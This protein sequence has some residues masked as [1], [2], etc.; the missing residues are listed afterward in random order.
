MQTLSFSLIPLLLILGSLFSHVA[1]KAQP[2][3]SPARVIRELYKVHNDG[4]GGIFE[5]KGK[6]YIYKFF[7]QKLADLIWKDITETPEGE[8]G[9]L[10]F[11]PLYN[12]QDTGITN[13]QIGKPMVKGDESTVL[14]SFRNFG[15]RTR[16]KFAMHNSKEGWRVRNV[17]YGDKSDL[18]KLL[19][20]PQSRNESQT[21]SP[22]PVPAPEQQKASIDPV[23]QFLLTAAATDF[24]TN[25]R[26]DSVR[27]RDV[28]LGHVMTPRGPERYMLCGQFLATHEGG[29]AEWTLFVTIKTSGYEQWN[30]VQAAGF[31][32]GSSVIWDKEG[33]LSSALQSRLDSLQ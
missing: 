30:G 17:L 9:N 8:V 33:D 24:H 12:A 28:R 27:F 19:S 2:T 21:V 7:D 3:N 5:A 11:D 31:C 18:I 15:Q 16:I 32:Q 23:V 14:V 13:F 4:K 26:S 25:V 10:D 6:K 22:T 29:K 1:Q 20:P